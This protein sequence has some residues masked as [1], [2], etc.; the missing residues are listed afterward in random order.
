MRLVFMVEERSMKE[1]LEI[2]LPRILPNNMEIPLIIPHSGKSD[3][4]KSIPI[5]LK[6]WQNPDD[7][8]IILHDQDSHDCMQLKADLESLCKNSK[9]DCL[10]R[11][12]CTELESWYFGDLTAVSLAYGK[13]Y[14]SLGVKR[15]YREPDKLK[16]AKEELHKL[17]PVYQPLSG[18]RK[19]AV[20]MDKDQNTSPSFK[21]FV[22]GVEKMCVG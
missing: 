5:K 9:N 22:R 13:D 17:I 4:A 6:A 7:K 10:I 11:I 21:V 19:I 1:L 2:I 3:L 14:T 16:N 12:V 20:H 15:K 8:F 18:A